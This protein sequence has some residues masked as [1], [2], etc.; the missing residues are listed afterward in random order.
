MHHFPQNDDHPVADMR[1]GQV[2]LKGIY[3]TL[4]SNPALW[5]KTLLII[6]YDEH[7]GFYDH[8]VPPIADLRDVRQ[9]GSADPGTGGSVGTVAGGVLAGVAGATISRR[10]AATEFSDAL[11]A[12]QAAVAAEGAARAGLVPASRLD[13]LTPY[14][15]RVP[16]FLVSPWVP[17]GKGPDIVLDHCSILKTILARFVARRRPSQRPCR[18]VAQLTFS[19]AAA[20]AWSQGSASAQGSAARQRK[21]GRSIATEPM[22]RAAMRHGNVDYHDLTGWL[23]RAPGAE[24]RR[25]V[26]LRAALRAE[27]LGQPVAL[28]HRLLERR[29]VRV[30]R[31]CDTR[32]ASAEPAI[33]SVSP[34]RSKAGLSYSAMNSS[35]RA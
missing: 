21:T 1:N 8:V 33:S 31:G 32:A 16:T 35:V 25:A 17:P 22:S 18:G 2:F 14:G 28:S 12:G 26:G 23:A 13:C 3:D 34:F 10:S 5:R 11:R 19:S 4:R 6:T 27:H 7:G 29:P 30:L 15:V 24:H 9:I 20:R